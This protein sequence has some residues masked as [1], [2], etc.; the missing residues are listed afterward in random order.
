MQGTRA[1]R[2]V[3]LV[4]LVLH[5]ALLRSVEAFLP[6]VSTSAGR[7]R[8]R[9]WSCRH[10]A[11]DS[12]AASVDAPPGPPPPAKFEVN[13]F[14]EYQVEGGPLSLGLV[15]DNTVGNRGASCLLLAP[16]GKPVTIPMDEVRLVLTSQ[17]GSG[18]TWYDNGSRGAAEGDAHGRRR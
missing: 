15:Q 13:S 9:G 17:P 1:A 2:C 3:P 8:R 4:S 6:S 7:H 5:L 10:A 11:A 14:A 18:G 12:E 16:D